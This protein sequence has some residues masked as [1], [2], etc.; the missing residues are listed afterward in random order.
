MV[1]IFSCECG[2]QR[3]NDPV[4]LSFHR[5]SFAEKIPVQAHE[6]LEN[7]AAPNNEVQHVR[8]LNK[9]FRRGFLH[10]ASSPRFVDSVH[11]PLRHEAVP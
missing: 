5:E 2:I 7:T 3:V 11:I 1:F 4:D 6:A 9:V 8:N 10:L